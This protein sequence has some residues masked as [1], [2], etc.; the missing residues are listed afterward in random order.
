MISGIDF[1]EKNF[2]LVGEGCYDLAGYRQVDP[3]TGQPFIITKW[4]MDLED[5]QTIIQNGGC[6]Y[7]SFLGVTIPPI[8]VLSANPFESK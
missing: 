4:Q 2:T 8:S 3:N 5:L 7:I 6:F 1:P